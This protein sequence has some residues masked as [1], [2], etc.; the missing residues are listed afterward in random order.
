M[1]S[2]TLKPNNNIL[3]IVR[4]YTFQIDCKWNLFD[5]TDFSDFSVPP[6]R[7]N[8]VTSSSPVHTSISNFQQTHWI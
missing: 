8:S 4:E 7:N 2:L 5:P 6:S 1:M 3:M